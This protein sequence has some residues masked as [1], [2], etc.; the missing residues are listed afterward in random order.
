MTTK[1]A[2]SR[3]TRLFCRG[4]SGSPPAIHVLAIGSPHGDDQ[5]SWHVVDRLG[6]NP[7]P[8][9]HTA[10]LNDPVGVLDYLEGCERLVLVDACRSGAEPGTVI[11][12][13]WPDARLQERESASTHGFGVVKVLELAAVLGDLPSHVVLIGVEALTCAPGAEISPPV[14]RALPRLYRQLLT[15]VLDWTTNPT[16]V[17]AGEH[18]GPMP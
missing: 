16:P 17:V 2:G 7:L 4:R 1:L 8:G 12:L 15:E 11:R 5:V 9:L 13:V 18:G 3:D 14:R 10:A 6:R